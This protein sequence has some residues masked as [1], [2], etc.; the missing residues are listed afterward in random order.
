MEADN[1][2]EWPAAHRE[3]TQQSIFHREFSMTILSKEFNSSF[4]CKNEYCKN[5]FCFEHNLFGE[6]VRP[7][8]KTMWS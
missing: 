1:H 7:D 2:Q 4:D 5:E 6:K 8:L 3:I